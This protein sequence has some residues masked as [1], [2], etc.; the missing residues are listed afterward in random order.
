MNGRIWLDVEDIFEYAAYNARPSGIQRV[1]VELC[2]ALAE[3][4]PA[5][6]RIG[7]IRHDPGGGSFRIVPRDD[8][9]AVGRRF[10]ERAGGPEPPRLDRSEAGLAPKGPLRRGVKQ[11]IYRLPPRL[12]QPLVAFLL[13]QRT[14]IESLGTLLRAVSRPRRE[15]GVRHA[16][17]RDSG[18]FEA[19]ARPGDV[20]LVTGAIWYHPGYAGVLR[21]NCATR[22]I[23]FALLVYDL[24]PIRR[25]E[26]CDPGHVR[27]FREWF[28]TALGIADQ[29]LSI[30]RASADD[31]ERYAAEQGRALPA[32]VRI[33]PLGTGFAS[34]REA[35][36]TRSP[37]RPLPPAGSYALIVSTLEVRKN[38]ILLF[39]VWRRLLD[40]LPR[41][42][43]PT[44]VFAG[45]VGWMVADL[46]QQL[47]NCDFL[48]GK[49][50]L[51]GEPTDAELEQ[52]YVGCQ[53]TLFPS[54]HEGWGLPVTESL[55]FGRPCIVS[56]TTSLPE[57]GGTLARYFDPDSVTDAYAV[58]RDALSD[59]AALAAWRQRVVDEFRAIS[60]RETASVVL[61]A[62]QASAIPRP[63]D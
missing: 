1:Q 42:Q 49:I 27:L 15:G 55:S 38:H 61:E 14:A 16:V 43:V 5:G 33:L 47:R 56:N 20:V 12:R 37:A 31:I 13:H 6:E 54:F 11:A 58:I 8:V 22:G 30:S 9:D 57:A 53:F 48:D 26:W 19:V 23:R 52:L 35:A 7:F 4:D 46:I 63:P 28:D 50:M 39:R 17:P 45:R 34:D 29:L 51:L 32:P 44:L 3:L 10:H 40:D 36:E 18:P 21:A 60:W 62:L 59:P 25:P 2:R 41:E 24:I